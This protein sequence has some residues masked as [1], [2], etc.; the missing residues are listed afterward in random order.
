M[1]RGLIY[2]K[3]VLKYLQS[4]YI[5]HQAFLWKDVPF[6]FIELLKLDNLISN[7]SILD[8]NNTAIDIGCDILM[9]DKEDD[10]DITIIQCKNYSEKN[11]CV[12]DLS[13]FFFILSTS[14]AP[15]KGMIVSNTDLSNRIIY[16]LNFTEKIKF[17]NLKYGENVVD[18]ETEM[19][20]EPRSYQIDAFN[21]FKDIDKG[22]MQMPCGLVE[23]VK[24]SQ[25]LCCRKDTMI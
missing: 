12:K 17:V 16:R 23:W 3:Q 24:L 15:I 13:G 19:L 2:E 7:R 18:E 21:K 8:D 25:V 5:D 1:E 6:K 10:E 20:L 22:I 4:S 9:V 14:N 11:V